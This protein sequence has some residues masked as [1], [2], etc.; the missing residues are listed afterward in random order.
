MVEILSYQSNNYIYNTNSQLSI[1]IKS[2]KKKGEKRK[3]LPLKLQ[4]IASKVQSYYYGNQNQTKLYQIIYND[5]TSAR[6]K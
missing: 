4:T 5:I 6:N 2:C 3:I 1:P